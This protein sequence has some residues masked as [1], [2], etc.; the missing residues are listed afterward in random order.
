MK[1]NKISVKTAMLLLLLAVL[2]GG[3]IAALSADRATQYTVGDLASVPVGS[4]QIIYKGAL[5]CVNTLGYAM[6]CADKS[7]WRF[8]GVAYNRADNQDGDSADISVTV[9]R[10]GTFLFNASSIGQEDVGAAMYVKSDNTFDDSSSN[11]VVCGRLA[12]YVS[13]TS[14]WISIDAAVYTAAAIPAAAITI[15]DGGNFTSETTAEGALQELYQN[16]IS[17]QGWIPVPLTALRE[18]VSNDIASITAA[19]SGS[20]VTFSGYGSLLHKTTTPILEFTNGDTDSALRL[21]WAASNSDPVVFQTPLPPDLDTTA[22]LVI[23]FRAA[24][25]G[26]TNS[27][28]ISADTFFNEG[29][30]KVEDDSAAVTGTT[31]A[32]YIIT[33]D[34]GA[35]LPAGAQTMTVELTPGAHTTDKLYIFAVWIEYKRKLVIE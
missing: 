8:V 29:D 4:S 21:N 10:R 7:G 20:T 19:A 26:V 25:A 31:P 13:A 22:D 12:Q 24:S 35:D 1:K 3:G 16:A 11:Y 33:I 2:A 9:Y 5:V 6:P 27:P 17:I 18:S 30:T 15:A 28:V 32:E 34:G 23:H 14:G